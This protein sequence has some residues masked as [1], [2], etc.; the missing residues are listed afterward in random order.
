MRYKLICFSILVLPLAVMIGLAQLDAPVVIPVT[1]HTLASDEDLAQPDTGFFGT[2][3][4]FDGIAVVYDI[5]NWIMSL[6]KDQEWRRTLVNDCLKVTEG[7]VVLDL[8]TGS[9][10]VAILA[11]ENVG[12]RGKV[13][14]VDP[15]VGMLTIGQ[16][17]IL[18]DPRWPRGKIQLHVGNAE[19]LTKVAPLPEMEP[20]GVE[21]IADNSV[22][23]IAMS[24]GIRN[25]KNRFVALK[26]MKRVAKNS[27]TSR[28]CI[29][30]FNIPD[31]SLGPVSFIAR[32][33]IEMVIPMIG[34]I[35]N[36]G[37]SKPNEYQYLVESITNFPSPE[38]FSRIMYRAG[39][40]VESVTHI[41]YGAVQVYSARV[42]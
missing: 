13:L 19:N 22:D 32:Y 5:N 16:S 35:S 29:M 12:E 24:F 23:K 26:E 15:S 20:L 18:A 36:V 11:A 39:L 28:V 9:A 14:G 10:D 7:D 34:Y 27:D 31:A 25:V 40:T 37:Q 1:S 4:M 17:K 38:K 33:F 42:Q 8:A 21:S 3:E 41:A 2:G 6:G 30:E